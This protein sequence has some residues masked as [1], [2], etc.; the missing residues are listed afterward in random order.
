MKFHFI[1]I[2]ACIR[3]EKSHDEFRRV[4]QPSTQVTLLE[5]GQDMNDQITYSSLLNVNYEDD[6]GNQNST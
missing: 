3:C 1:G 6:D 2:Y 5:A 4:E